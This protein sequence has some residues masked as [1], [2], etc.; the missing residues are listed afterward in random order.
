[1]SGGEENA[2]IGLAGAPGEDLGQEGF[3][4]AGIADDDHAGA[5]LEEVQIEQ[6]ED[7]VFRLEARFVMREAKLVDGGLSG[8]AREIEAALDGA[9]VASFQL[10]IGQAFQGRREAKILGRG[11]GCD[12]LQCLSHGGQAQLA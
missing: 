11:L 6:T 2:H 4:H 8:E 9:A 10:Q 12:R 7:A 1:L 3:P 5:L